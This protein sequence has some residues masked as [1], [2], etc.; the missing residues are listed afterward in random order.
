MPT[1]ERRTTERRRATRELSLRVG[2]GYD[3]HALVPGRPL[4]LGDVTV[5]SELGLL[6]HSD[7]DVLT[8]AIIDALFCAAGL[9]DIG[10]HFPDTDPRFKGANSL[11]LLQHALAAVWDAGYTV[12]NIDSTVI[13]QGPRLAPH[14]EAIR[15]S[16]SAAALMPL[17]AVNVKAKTNE[18]LGFEGRQEGI[19]AHAVVLLGP[20]GS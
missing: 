12:I 19:V 18:R 11:K 16:L 9:G 17:D 8:H 3:L 15:A 6:G 4:V 13:A 14:I 20:A 1:S 7:A 10:S 2:Q 5:P